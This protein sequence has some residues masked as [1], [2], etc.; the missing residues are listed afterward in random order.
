VTKPEVLELLQHFDLDHSGSMNIF[1]VVRLDCPLYLYYRLVIARM[2]PCTSAPVLP[3]TYT[4]SCAQKPPRPFHSAT[5][6]CSR[7]APPTP[8]PVFFRR[9]EYSTPNGSLLQLPTAARKRGPLPRRPHTHHALTDLLPASNTAPPAGRGLPRRAPR[10]AHHRTAAAAAGAGIT[11]RRPGAPPRPRPRCGCGYGHGGVGVGVGHGPAGVGR[12]GAA[13]GGGS[14]GGGSASPHTCHDPT[15]AVE[16][17]RGGAAAGGG[18]AEPPRESRDEGRLEVEGGGE[19][20][21]RGV[22]LPAPLPR[23]QPRR[24]PVAHRALSVPQAAPAVDAQSQSQ[25]Q[26]QS[27]SGGGRGR[28]AGGRGGGGV[29]GDAGTGARARDAHAGGGG[30]VCVWLGG[31]VSG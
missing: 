5:P 3:R 20:G 22:P 27:G 2:L 1:E 19:G 11:G 14:G 15:A 24:A 18:C 8:Q 25:P 10:R 30:W 13:G 21:R 26:A 28:G 4:F 17:G 31:W 9:T 29:A 6:F 23:G 16:A 7:R 12:G